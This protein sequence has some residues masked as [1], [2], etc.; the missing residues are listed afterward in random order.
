VFGVLAMLA[1]R[2]IAPAAEGMGVGLDRTIRSIELAG[3]AASQLYAMA[4][5][6]VAVAELLVLSR[7]RVS[8]SIRNAAIGIG[9]F[10]VLVTLAAAATRVPAVS[11]ALVG[12]G[13]GAMCMLVAR[14]ARH[15]PFARTVAIGLAAAGLTSL[16]RLV[17]VGLAFAAS[18]F[19]SDRLAI[20]ARIGA[21]IAFVLDGATLAVAAAWITARSKKLASPLVA[22]AF[23]VAVFA[24][25]E[26]VRHD[27]DP[28][29][30]VVL[31]RR[32]VDRLVTRPEPFVPVQA[33]AFVA[34]LAP[35]LA[36]ACVVA[37]GMLP[38]LAGGFA[39][40][41]FAKDA[42]EMPLGA[43]S[44]LVGTVA[45]ALGAHDER[46]LWAS[47]REIEARSDQGYGAA[48]SAHQG[49]PESSPASGQG[50]GPRG[51]SP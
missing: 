50:S 33:A 14:D 42:P 34:V 22:I 1:G 47:I 9:G 19:A 48:T 44:M 35:A 3:G 7:S 21:T 5:T 36:L 8:A 29:P 23:V 16:V 10:V 45:I 37:R 12:V 25:R 4:A 51:S 32:A 27:D 24:T 31:V 20:A 39:L 43:L 6:I 49:P 15:I 28:G 17:A 40:V 26:Y 2:A 13:A 46:T 11:A 38:V 41:L 18:R 30:F